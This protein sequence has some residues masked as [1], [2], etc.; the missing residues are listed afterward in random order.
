[1]PDQL[2]N[3]LDRFWD[4]RVTGNLIDGI[5]SDPVLEE[6][7]HRFQTAEDVNRAD[8]AFVD[9]LWEDLM[10]ATATTYPPVTSSPIESATV[11]GQQD[12]RPVIELPRIIR[13][14]LSAVVAAAILLAALGGIA[15]F[16][17]LDRGDSGSHTGAP[18]IYAPATPSPTAE[19]PNAT[20]VD[21]VLPAGTLS[22]GGKTGEDGSV[23]I[24]ATIPPNTNGTWTPAADD[25]Q[26]DGIRLI[27][28]VDGS[29][30]IKADGPVQVF[31]SDGS[32]SAEA[33]ATGSDATLGAGD[34]ALFASS[35]H[36]ETSNPQTTP[37]RIV[38]WVKTGLNLL[39]DNTAYPDTWQVAKTY[40][41]SG[42]G[43]AV[44]PA[45][46][47]AVTLRLQ[48]E[49][50]PANAS[51]TV[52]LTDTWFLITDPALSQYGTNSDQSITNVTTAP[53]TYFV[54]TLKPTS[55]TATPAP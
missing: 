42:V 43:G 31:R 16:W 3:E 11:S 10:S 29:I 6:V 25:C 51:S 4:A 19:S 8:P 37:A 23:F 35:V 55:D 17:L 21:T 14:Q 45:L 38:Y 50:V 52:R 32:E 40:D 22:K 2:M 53:V 54:I 41:S 46:A 15:G 26:C 9:H 5:L 7:V 12:I 36:Y 20:L 18:A 27:S 49:T 13:H 28:V 34:T 44:D 47:G 1:M 33:I 39:N 30:V 24:L 48:R